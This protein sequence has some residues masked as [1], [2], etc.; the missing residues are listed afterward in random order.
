MFDHTF[1]GGI[2]GASL[3]AQVSTGDGFV[4]AD[5]LSVESSNS[6]RIQAEADLASGSFGTIDTLDGVSWDDGGVFTG[7]QTVTQT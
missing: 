3:L 7:P 1:T 6:I 5:L 4:F 2:G